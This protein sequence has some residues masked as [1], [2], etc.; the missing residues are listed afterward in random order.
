MGTMIICSI[1]IIIT[2]IIIINRKKKFSFKKPLSKTSST[3]APAVATTPPSPK[4]KVAKSTSVWKIIAIALMV[5]IAI[6]SIF[7]V[8]NW[9]KG[10]KKPSTKKPK[11]EVEYMDVYFD[12]E[13]GKTYYI[14]YNTNFG[15]RDADQPYCVMDGDGNEFCAEKGCDASDHMDPYTEANH[16]QKFRSKNGQSGHLRIKLYKGKLNR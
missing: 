10:N 2:I 6:I 16:K 9:Y 1:I 4:Q 7:E 5:M 3:P 13:Y 12:G 11:T 14:P 15:F 8:G